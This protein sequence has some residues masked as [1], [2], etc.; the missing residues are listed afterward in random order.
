MNTCQTGCG[1]HTDTLYLCP[2]CTD[3][4][5]SNLNAVGWLVDELHITYSR[6]HRFTH[7]IGTLA[8]SPDEPVPYHQQAATAAAHLDTALEQATHLVAPDEHDQ[9]D[10]TTHR[11]AHLAR[12]INTLRTHPSIGDIALGIDHAI[13]HATHT[14]DRPPETIYIGPCDQCGHDLN[15]YTHRG[16]VTCPACGVTYDIHER[17]TRL[18]EALEDQLATTTE[19]C[20]AFTVLG[21]PLTAEQLRKWASRGKLTRRAPH[22]ADPKHRPRYRV[23]D[24]AALAH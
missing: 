2:Q 21:H 12:H 15:A 17:R 9:Q 22:P 16:T 7:L 4:L 18:L 5:R 3:V 13:H 8:R 24:V 14:I 6:Q 23:G 1:T 19:L 10:T 20:R 11:A